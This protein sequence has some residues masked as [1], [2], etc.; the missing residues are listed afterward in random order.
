MTTIVNPNKSLSVNPLKMSQPLG[1]ALAFLGLNKMMPLFHG[2]QGCTAFAKVVLVRHFRESIPLSTTAM[3][4]ISTI[5][6]GEE[7]IEQAILTIMD[8]YKPEVI[9]LL[10]TGLTETRGDDMNRILL[11]I[12]EKHPHLRSFPIILVST[13]DYKGS[14]QDG[15]SAAVESIVS[16]DYGDPI[17]DKLCSTNIKSQVNVLCASYLSPGDVEEI[18]VTIESFGLVPIMI[19]DLSCSLDGHVEDEY[20][21]TTTGGTSLQQLRQL[22]HSCL[23]LAIGESMTKAAIVLE[24]RFGTKYEV[25]PSLAGL[26][27]IDSF[28]WKLSQFVTS[29]NNDQLISQAIPSR[30]KRQRRQLQDVILD[31]H[32]YFGGKKISLA[33]EPDLLYQTSWLLTEMGAEIQ[34]AVTTSES[35]ILKELPFDT[36]VIGDLKDLEELAPGS[37]LIIT[38]SH[39]TS[40]A[41][42][43]KIPLY[44][45]GYPVYDRL[46]MGQRCLIGYSGTMRFLFDV[47][48]LLM[49]EEAKHN[50]I[51]LH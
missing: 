1:A 4:E 50:P 21:T 37:D 12:K 3:T 5:L 49:E 9:G 46:G 14:L 7:N 13:P 30:L 18:K 33:L 28:L 24:K 34:A 2:S 25:F 16:T 35:S 29:D 11:T 27:A 44:R 31:T 32:F 17:Q 47:G 41:D 10:T 8:K 45:M 36:V 48:N 43:F 15:Y 38:N 42:E 40:L 39:G 51:T 26:D 6:G 23:T 22:K 20:H 19:P